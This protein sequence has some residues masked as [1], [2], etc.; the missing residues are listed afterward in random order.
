MYSLVWGGIAWIRVG[1]DRRHTEHRLA[2]AR[3]SKYG[4]DE[5]FDKEKNVFLCALI[6]TGISWQ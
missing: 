2:V 4:L 1:R 3:A 6:V 5:V